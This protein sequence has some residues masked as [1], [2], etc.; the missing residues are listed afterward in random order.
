MGIGVNQRQPFLD[1]FI[2]QSAIRLSH[3]GLRIY[4]IFT[5]QLDAGIVNNNP[6]GNSMLK[7]L[8]MG[9]LK[10]IFNEWN[11]YHRGDPFLANIPGNG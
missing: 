10:G 2:T 9:M 4:L 1:E 7:F 11:E 6:D 5:K 8:V 3:R